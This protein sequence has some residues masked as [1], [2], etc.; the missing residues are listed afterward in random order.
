MKFFISLI[1]GLGLLLMIPLEAESQSRSPVQD[2]RPSVRPPSSSR[3]PGGTRNPL[4]PSRRTQALGEFGWEV[5]GNIGTSLSLTEVSGTSVDQKPSFLNSQWNATRLN[6]GGFGRYRFNN[7]LAVRGSINYGRMSGADSLATGRERNF[8]FTNNIFELGVVGEVYAPK[9]SQEFPLDFYGFLGF[10]GF[11]HNPK[12]QVPEPIPND[13]T[14]DSYS[15][16]QAAI[17]VG[18]GINYMLANGIKVGYEIGYRK[19]FT[20]YL[21]GFTRPYSQGNDAYYF[22]TIIITYPLQGTG[23]R[24]RF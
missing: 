4:L 13:F 21:D 10:A 9:S 11:Y 5:G 20:D 23:S 3:P 2:R 17:P 6:L 8:A 16:I 15:N 19:L 24:V 14:F 7:L 22:T 1:F 18:I 12:L